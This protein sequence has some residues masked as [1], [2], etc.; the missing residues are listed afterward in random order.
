[1]EGKDFTLVVYY[2]WSQGVLWAAKH[3]PL[4][5]AKRAASSGLSAA[6]QYAQRGLPTECGLFEVFAREVIAF[7]RME[8]LMD[9]G[10]PAEDMSSTFPVSD[11]DFMRYLCS[12]AGDIYAIVQTL[13]LTDQQRDAC[14]IGLLYWDFSDSSWL[15]GWDKT[16][17]RP[18]LAAV[19]DSCNRTAETLQEYDE[20]I[21]VQTSLYAT[22]E[23]ATSMLWLSTLE[24]KGGEKPH[25]EG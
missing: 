21:V 14:A 10:Q 18:V 25:G 6:F 5:A 7:T 23:Y 17:R 1:M 13:K 11:G 8:V 22:N 4:N 9:G 15:D 24:Q 20:E 2:L 19:L 3:L 16:D 12:V